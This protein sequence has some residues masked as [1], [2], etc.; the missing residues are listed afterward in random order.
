VPVEA[1]PVVALAPVEAAQ[2]AP[3]AAADRAEEAEEREG[4]AVPE[5]SDD[6]PFNIFGAEDGNGSR[7]VPAQNDAMERVRAIQDDA[8]GD[9]GDEDRDAFEPIVVPEI[10]PANEVA[11]DRRDGSVEIVM[12]DVDAMIDEITAQAT[13]PNRNPNVGNAGRQDDDQDEDD[14]ESSGRERDRGDRDEGDR[15]D[16]RDTSPARN[17]ARTIRDR[18][19]DQIGRGSNSRSSGE[20]SSP[21]NERGGRGNNQDPTDDCFPFC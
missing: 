21:V 1:V 8:D 17:R 11:T 16:D 9:D 20:R 4:R 7:I 15:D 10:V 6:D 19:K 3:T 14:R 2:P 12:P 18:I 5:Q 13:D